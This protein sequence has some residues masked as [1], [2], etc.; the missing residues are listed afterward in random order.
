MIR[1]GTLVCAAGVAA[2]FHLEERCVNEEPVPKCVKEMIEETDLSIQ[3]T[4]SVRR[5][6]VEREGGNC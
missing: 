5:T 6:P 4:V 2:Q 1:C 3:Y